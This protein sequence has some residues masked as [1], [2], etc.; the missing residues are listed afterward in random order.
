MISSSAVQ[1]SIRTLVK[2]VESIH[3]ECQCQ[4]QC[5]W[6]ML[7]YGDVVTLENQFQ[8]HSQVSQCIPI[9]AATLALPLTLGVGYPLVYSQTRQQCLIQQT[10]SLTVKP[11]LAIIPRNA[12]RNNFNRLT[13]LLPSDYEFNSHRRQFFQNP[14]ISILYKIVIFVFF[15]ETPF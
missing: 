6:P 1:P 8:T 11:F 9:K 10:H 5:K 15:S 12:I 14:F 2:I 4:R 3:T 7:V 13:D